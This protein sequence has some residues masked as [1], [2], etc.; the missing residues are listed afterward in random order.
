MGQQIFLSTMGHQ[1]RCWLARLGRM[2][3]SKD[4]YILMVSDTLLVPNSVFYIFSS[5]LLLLHFPLHHNLI[6][7]WGIT[8]DSRQIA[9]GMNSF[10]LFILWLNHLLCQNKIFPRPASNNSCQTQ[11]IT[12]G[13]LRQE[14][15]V[16][17]VC[18]GYIMCL[19]VYLSIYQNSQMVRRTTV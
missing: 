19:S 16:F 11:I 7:S 13:R 9:L 3:T 10:Y 18:M 12:L 15:C 6:V 8:S 4:R 5:N 2:R 17:K 14:S 1:D